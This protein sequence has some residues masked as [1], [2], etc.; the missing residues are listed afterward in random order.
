MN[1][2]GCESHGV[3]E[4]Y[5]GFEDL[6]IWEKEMKIRLNIFIHSKVYPVCSCYA[7]GRRV[8]FVNSQFLESN[9]EGE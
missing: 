1:S 8:T 9:P 5:D 7:P 3:G 6:K 2:N 4:T